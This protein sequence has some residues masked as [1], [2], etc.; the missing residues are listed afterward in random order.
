MS[1][2]TNCIFKALAW[3]K[4]SACLRSTFFLLMAVLLME[5]LRAQEVESTNNLGHAVLSFPPILAWEYR[6]DLA[7]ES[8]NAFISAGEGKAYDFLFRTAKQ[9]NSS[10][11]DS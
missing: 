9:T 3:M 1:A 8:A 6:P 5:G 7:I 11:A 2:I 10:F 4:L